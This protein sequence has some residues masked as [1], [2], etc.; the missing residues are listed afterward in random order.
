M[1]VPSDVTEY[2][3]S[4]V[5]NREPAIV[6]IEKYAG[7]HGVP[8]MELVGIEAM[9]Q[10]LRLVQPKSILEVG[11]AIGYSAIR[12]AKV[13]P[14]VRIVT[15]ERDKNRYDKAIENIEK[16]QLQERITVIFGDALE[17]GEQVGQNGPFDSIFIDAAKGQY[18]R[19]F[20][21]YSPMLSQ[22]GVVFSDNILF[23]GLVAKNNIED[24]RHKSLVEKIKGYNKWLMNHP[25]FDTTIL[26][27]GDGIAISRKR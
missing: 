11:T 12:M 10:F 4:L 19:F 17:T 9:L 25:E 7:E 22:N 26:T 18:T 27:V 16:M 13:L 3:E 14:N 23:R 6:E 24:R 15:I 20:E 21:L 2:I 5:P 8:I 1:F